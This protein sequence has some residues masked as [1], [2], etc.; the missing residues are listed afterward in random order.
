MAQSKIPPRADDYA[1][2]YQDVIAQAELAEAAGVVKGCMVIR[3]HGYAVWEK[4][5]ERNNKQVDERN[6]VSIFLALVDDECHEIV[7]GSHRRWRTPFEHDVLLPKDM[8]DAGV[9]HT[10]T[11]GVVLCLLRLGRW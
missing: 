4:I 11:V 9:P 5:Q 6:G 10:P 8:K 2:W 3:P 1:Q 7:A